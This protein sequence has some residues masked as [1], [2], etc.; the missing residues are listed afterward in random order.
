[1]RVLE[2]LTNLFHR[3]RPEQVCLPPLEHPPRH[4]VKYHDLA[5]TAAKAEAHAIVAE[6]R[7]ERRQR[8]RTFAEV[9]RDVYLAGDGSGGGR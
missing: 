3:P 6:R 4:Q 8:E 9:Q 7:L 5:N 1:M 2:M